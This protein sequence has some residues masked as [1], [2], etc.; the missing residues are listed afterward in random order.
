V[1]ALRGGKVG[2]SGSIAD[3]MHWMERKTV[4]RQLFKLLPKSTEMATAVDVDERTGSDLRAT[5]ATPLP[6][7]IEQGVDVI[8]GEIVDETAWPTAATP[9]GE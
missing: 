4:L 1:K 9:G 6:A 3:P 5:G 2:T 7:A 8:T